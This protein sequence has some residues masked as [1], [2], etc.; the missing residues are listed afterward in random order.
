MLNNPAEYERD[1]SSVK[2]TTTS[3][4][5]SPCFTIRGYSWRALVDEL[6][7]FRTEMGSAQ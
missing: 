5:V 6:G 2:F 3:Q 7:M 1:T 4:R